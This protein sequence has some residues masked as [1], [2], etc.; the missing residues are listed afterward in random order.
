[1]YH[2]KE[3]QIKVTQEWLQ[4]RFESI[5]YLDIMKGWWSKGNFRYKPAAIG[6]KASKL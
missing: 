5:N 2:F 1:M 4:N 3:S 6:W